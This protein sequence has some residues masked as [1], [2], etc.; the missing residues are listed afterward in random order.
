M[1][2]AKLSPPEDETAFQAFRKRAFNILSAISPEDA[3]RLAFNSG[4]AY[5]LKQAAGML[6]KEIHNDKS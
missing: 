1:N 6:E 5:G 3:Q 2:E 4:Q